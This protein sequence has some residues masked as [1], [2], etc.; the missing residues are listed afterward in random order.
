MVGGRIVAVPGKAGNL[1]F[2]RHSGKAMQRRVPLLFMRELAATL[3]IVTFV[4]F[5]AISWRV[6]AMVDDVLVRV[7][8]LRTQVLGDATKN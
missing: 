4:L 5:F 7:T 2:R 3:L 6:A 1:P 8:R